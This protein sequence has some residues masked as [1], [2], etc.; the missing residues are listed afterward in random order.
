[1]QARHYGVLITLGHVI[2]ENKL[3]FGFIAGESTME[4]R[5]YNEPSG[6]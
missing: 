3:H 4:N 1:M 5:S 6:F 2:R